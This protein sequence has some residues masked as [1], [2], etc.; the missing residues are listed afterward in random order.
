MITKNR[1][2]PAIKRFCRMSLK[3]FLVSDFWSAYHA[4]VCAGKQKCLTHLLRELRNVGRKK[5]TVA[6]TAGFPSVNN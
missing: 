3:F 2:H 1:G 6:G 4:V 5:G